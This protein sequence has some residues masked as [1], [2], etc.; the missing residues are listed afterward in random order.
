MKDTRLDHLK[1]FYDLLVVLEGK[2]GGKRMLS[3]CSGRIKWPERGVY[4]F[5]ENGEKRSDSGQG[6]RVVRVGTHALHATSRT[7]LWKRLSQ[8]QGTVRTG[9]GNHR[10]SIFRLLV[11]SALAGKDKS[12]SVASWGR[13]TSADKQTRLG[14]LDHEKRVSAVIGD[15]PFVWLEIGDPPGPNS[16]RLFIEQNSIALL[17]NYARP[18]IDPPSP[19]W[20]GQFCERERV[21]SSGLWNQRHVDEQVDP[22]YLDI[23]ARLISDLTNAS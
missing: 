1:R 13:G 6:L 4:F 20:L 16:L 18:A 7:T 10:G 9:G 15:M 17:S 14:E 12:S 21:R 3:N 19:L 8:H 22:S 23:L 5:F 2:I 11:G